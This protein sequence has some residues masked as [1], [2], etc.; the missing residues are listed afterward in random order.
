MIVAVVVCLFFGSAFAV[1]YYLSKR[2]GDGA[3]VLTFD[4]PYVTL[5]TGSIYGSDDPEP[6][7]DSSSEIASHEDDASQGD[8]DSDVDLS[9]PRNL[10][11]PINAGKLYTV[12]LDEET[13]D[14]SDHDPRRPKQYCPALQVDDEEEQFELKAP[15]AEQDDDDDDFDWDNNGNYDAEMNWQ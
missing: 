15:I 8:D 7:S 10:R 2:S 6:L 9:P 13:P 5:R 4:G 3:P 12:S 1:I 14:D 11:L